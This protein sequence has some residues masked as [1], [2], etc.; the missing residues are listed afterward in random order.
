MSVIQDIYNDFKAIIFIALMILVALWFIFLNRF[1]FWITSTFFILAGLFLWSLFSK[2]LA[3]AIFFVFCIIGVYHF[4]SRPISEHGKHNYLGIEKVKVYTKRGEDIFIYDPNFYY[5]PDNALKIIGMRKWELTTGII[6]S[7]PSTKGMTKKEVYFNKCIM[8]KG[9]GGKLEYRDLDGTYHT[10]YDRKFF[11]FIK[12][13][14][15]LSD[16]LRNSYEIDG[17]NIWKI[18]IWHEGQ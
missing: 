13:K 8:I 3:L 5:S 18:E 10:L 4:A 7:I 12:I 1:G 16:R 14:G 9:W 15:F 2:N 6:Y 17:K 11:E